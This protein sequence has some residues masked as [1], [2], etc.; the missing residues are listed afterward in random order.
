[1]ASGWP[2]VDCHLN[3]QTLMISC[4][5]KK[6]RATPYTLKGVEEYWVIISIVSVCALMSQCIISVR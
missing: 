3:K 4:L 6:R 1:M 5:K 2:V